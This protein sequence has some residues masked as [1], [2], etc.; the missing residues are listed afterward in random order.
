MTIREFVE[1]L[2]TNAQEHPSHMT[3]SEAE[4]DLANF[5]ADGWQLPEGMTAE[6]YRDAWNALVAEADGSEGVDLQEIT[7]QES[8]IVWYPDNTVFVGNWVNTTIDATVVSSEHYDRFDDVATI[9][10]AREVI[11]DNGDLANG[12]AI[13]DD[14]MVY[15]LSDGTTVFAPHEW[16]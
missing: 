11:D 6:D 9:S 16:N 10:G 15:E 14:G 5:A 4:T 1:N 2:Y 3:L 8:G 13:A 12:T 7:H